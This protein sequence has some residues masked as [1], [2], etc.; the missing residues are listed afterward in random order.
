MNADIIDGILTGS[1]TFGQGFSTSEET[2]QIDIDTVGEYSYEQNI[3]QRNISMEIEAVGT[4]TEV[5]AAVIE[6]TLN[7]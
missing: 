1:G 4:C 7:Q 2:I 6:K 5:D 3:R